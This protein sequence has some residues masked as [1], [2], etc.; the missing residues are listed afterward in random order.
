M[1]VLD[2][3]ARSKND[4]ASAINLPFFV[5]DI[6]AN[7]PSIIQNAKDQIMTD[8]IQGFQHHNKNFNWTG[9]AE[10]DKKQ[11]ELIFDQ[12]KLK[13]DGSLAQELSQK[14]AE[15][16]DGQILSGG[17]LY[18]DFENYLNSDSYAAISK[19]AER[20]VARAQ[21]VLE[22]IANKL[23]AYMDTLRLIEEPEKLRRI[24]AVYQQTG[25]PVSESF[26][27]K[28]N[29][30]KINTTGFNAKVESNL[31]NL[32]GIINALA[33]AGVSE[34]GTAI[35]G[36]YE[37]DGKSISSPQKLLSLAIAAFNNIGSEGIHESL[38]AFGASK[39]KERSIEIWDECT[40]AFI[41]SGFKVIGSSNE[42][43]NVGEKGTKVDGQQLK[44]DVKITW[45]GNTWTLEFGVSDKLRQG[46]NAIGNEGQPIGTVAPQGIFLGELLAMTLQNGNTSFFEQNWSALLSGPGRR[47]KTFN[48]SSII[49]AAELWNNFKDAARYI[50]LFRGLVGTGLEGD[51]ASILVVN[52]T[53]FSVYDILKNVN[54]SKN[55]GGGM[56]Y[57]VRWQKEIPEFLEL[58]EQISG[59]YQKGNYPEQNERIAEQQAMI[60]E[61]YNKK[62]YIEIQ[63]STLM[64]VL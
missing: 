34:K 52:S 14:Y 40:N 26:L 30:Q 3:Y 25:R 55:T 31:K 5:S 2:R 38:T 42:G 46:R 9:N 36:V 53:V 41:E 27:A 20:Y 6:T 39:V 10:K 48:N 54:S 56:S 47:Y 44:P 13:N 49:S 22:L 64:S 43:Q 23:G 15:L 28:Y 1:G 11:V 45:K 29:N 58:R 24:I 37:S 17:G 7:P 21:K 51:F 59:N 4:R 19:G 32:E 16:I 12:W 62:Y 63:L 50:A 35:H 60:E 61:I 57:A 18:G 8:F 33:A